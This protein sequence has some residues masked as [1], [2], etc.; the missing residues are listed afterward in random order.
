[1]AGAAL[2]RK[3]RGRRKGRAGPQTARKRDAP[4]RNRNAAVKLFLPD[5]PPRVKNK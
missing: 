2:D 3:G 1:V 4:G 5:Q